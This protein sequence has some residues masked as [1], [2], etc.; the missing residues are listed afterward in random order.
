MSNANSTMN[1]KYEPNNNIYMNRAAIASRDSARK[2]QKPFGFARLYTR[3]N[4]RNY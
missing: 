2:N 3:G 1:W 4:F